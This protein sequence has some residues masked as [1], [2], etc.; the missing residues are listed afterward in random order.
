MGLGLVCAPWGCGGHVS[1]GTDAHDA[2]P[3]ATPPAS[4]VVETLQDEAGFFDVPPQAQGEPYAGRIFYV[5]QPADDDAAHKPVAVFL[6]GGPGYPA[7]LDLL[8]YGIARSTLTAPYL[9][10]APPVTNP[11]R[12]TT[13]ANVLVLDERQSG[14][15]YGLRGDPD[16]ASPNANCAFSPIDDAADVVRSLL[17]FLDGHPALTAAP[18][19]FVGQ[20]Y[21]GARATL[22]LDLLLRYPTEASRADAALGGAI[23]AHYDAAFPDRSGAVLGEKAAVAQFGHAVLLQPLVLGSLQYT[24]Q[25]RLMPDDPYVGSPP[26]GRD[27]Y[28]VRQPAGWTTGLE[29]NAA[30]QIAD[31]SGGP[32]LLG[33]PPASI[34]RLGPASRAGAF[35]TAAPPSP[36]AMAIDAALASALGPLGSDDAYFVY[37]GTACPVGGLLQGIGSANE[38]VENLDGGVRTF[39][40][41]ARYDAVIYS[42]AIPATLEPAGTVVVDTAPRAGVARPGWFRVTLDG[43]AMPIDVRFPLYDSAG[44]FVSV[45]QPQDLRDDVA[46]WYAGQ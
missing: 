1:A 9:A 28:D 41:D 19:V 43:G 24:T 14:F 16:G 12:W 18:V 45:G 30:M 35:R 34:P 46:A 22:A 21:G 27:P 15:S 33:V 23:Q 2:G 10:G 39:I 20:S 31:P 8:P 11:A 4:E 44:H 36:G 29:E 5:F 6:A 42:P 17:Q 37:P 40:S 26:A 7:S 32:S 3:R 13:F 38:F 25:S